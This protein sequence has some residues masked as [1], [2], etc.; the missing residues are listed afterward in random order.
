MRL[1]QNPAL[2]YRT[3]RRSGSGRALLATALAAGLLAAPSSARAQQATLPAQAPADRGTALDA[4]TPTADDPWFF[5]ADHRQQLYEQSRL[6][7]S[8]AVLRNL[9]FPGLGNI[10]TEQYFYA[11]LA[12]SLMAFAASFASYGLV[13][14]QPEFLWT[15]AA[16]AGIAYAG[17]IATSIYGVH[18][19]NERLAMGLKLTAT[20]A[21]PG[22]HFTWH[23]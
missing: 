3:A 15:G 4:P 10:Y 20:A 1:H 22:L 18:D 9:L 5:G 7:P 21:T 11:G 14:D 8:Q 23:F 19:Y 16:T 2:F 12:M 6:T 17:S 13:T